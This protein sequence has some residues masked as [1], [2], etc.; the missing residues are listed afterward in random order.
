MK[1]VIGSLLASLLLSAIGVVSG[2]SANAV[3]C[4][5]FNKGT[6]T[7]FHV[8]EARGMGLYKIA[9]NCHFG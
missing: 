2:V 7:A 8:A 1:K 6:G 4:A 3:D 5:A 9:N